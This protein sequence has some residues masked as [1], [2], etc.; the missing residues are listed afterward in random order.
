MW[1]ERRC[2]LAPL[3]SVKSDPWICPPLN[4]WNWN[5]TWK[6]NLHVTESVPSTFLTSVE[7]A[8]EPGRKFLAGMLCP[9]KKSSKC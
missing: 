5:E 1:K 3:A 9:T 2:L 8:N 7:G 6:L 4:L